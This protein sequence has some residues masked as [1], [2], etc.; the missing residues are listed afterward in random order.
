MHPKPAYNGGNGVKSNETWTTGDAR[1]L[2]AAAAAHA[3]RAQIAHGAGG[4]RQRDNNGAAER[5]NAQ[6]ASN[7]HDR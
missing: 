1:C 6:P 7:D 4:G 3:G 5:L 2:Q